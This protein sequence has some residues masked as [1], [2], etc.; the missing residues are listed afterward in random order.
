MNLQLDKL[1]AS[2]AG[3]IFINFP[4]FP[5]SAWECIETTKTMMTKENISIP[6]QSM[7]TRK[8]LSF[9]SWH[10]RLFW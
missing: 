4:L 3:T 5:R 6:T 1:N 2:V 7:G 8:V 9:L 10:G